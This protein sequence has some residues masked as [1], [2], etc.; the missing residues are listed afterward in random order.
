MCLSPLIWSYES[1]SSELL[2]SVGTLFCVPFPALFLTIRHPLLTFKRWH[3][4]DQPKAVSI[5]QGQIQGYLIGVQN[6]LVGV[7]LIQLP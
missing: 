5:M 7:K 4:P 1:V 6:F 2:Q 3:K